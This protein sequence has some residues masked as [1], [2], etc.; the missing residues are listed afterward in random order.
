MIPFFL[1]VQNDCY[2]FLV[3]EL[4]EGGDMY[5]H[6]NKV[7]ALSFTCS[8]SH[9]RFNNNMGKKNAVVVYRSTAA[10]FD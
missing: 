7:S 6:L 8:V 10:T 2:V 1:L 9:M 5:G 4:L 3:L